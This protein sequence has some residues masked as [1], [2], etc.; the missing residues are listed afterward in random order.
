MTSIRDSLSR[1]KWLCNYYFS[2]VSLPAADKKWEQGRTDF[3]Q[4]KL[5]CRADCKGQDIHAEIFG[6][7]ASRCCHRE[8]VRHIFIK[9]LFT[10]RGDSK[11]SKRYGCKVFHR[12]KKSLPGNNHCENLEHEVVQ[13][14][15]M[16]CLVTFLS[17]QIYG[18]EGGLFAMSSWLSSA[19][20]VWTSPRTSFFF[21]CKWSLLYWQ[22]KDG[23][24]IT[25]K[26]KNEK[27]EKKVQRGV[28][29]NCD[30]W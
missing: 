12:H 17:R 1:T 8:E 10:K 4:Q 18:Q 23:C 30:G 5:A 21:R 15:T 20:R 16:N 25:C 14:I 28:D 2:R 6:K 13:K 29:R 3:V 22:W 9:K 24:R 7:T 27:K 19:W 26:K 11:Q